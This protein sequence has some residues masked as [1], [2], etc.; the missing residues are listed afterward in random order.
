MTRSSVILGLLSGFVRLRLGKPAGLGR[1]EHQGGDL[2]Q[3]GAEMPRGPGSAVRPRRRTA[4]E[5]GLGRSD[6]RKGKPVWDG[7]KKC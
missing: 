6:P 7:E 3:E 2:P 1:H 5:H 4:D